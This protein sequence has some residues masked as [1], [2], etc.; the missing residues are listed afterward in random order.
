MDMSDLGYQDPSECMDLYDEGDYALL[1]SFID[2]NDEKGKMSKGYN[3][4][5]YEKEVKI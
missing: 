2:L 4:I 1:Q 3:V 5:G